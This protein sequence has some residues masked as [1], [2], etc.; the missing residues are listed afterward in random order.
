MSDSSAFYSALSAN[1]DRMTRAQDRRQMEKARLKS[2]VEMYSIKSALDVACG[3]GLHAILLAELGVQVTAT[4]NSADMLQQA[5]FNAEQTNVSVRWLRCEMQNLLD[6]LDDR[7]DAIFCLGN[8]IP[9]LLEFEDLQ[10]TIAQFVALLKARGICLLQIL[11]YE[12][13]LQTKNRIVGIHRAESLEFVRFYDFFSELI[14]F[15]ILTIDWSGPNARH[16]LQS[17]QLRPYRAWEIELCLAHYLFSVQKYSSLSLEPFEPS[18]S[19][20]LVI[21]GAQSR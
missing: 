7:F 15:N 10:R 12:R 5:Q 14:Q 8:S 20:D 18:S 4:D 21:L 1:Y 6:C 16:S 3:T 17:T 9:H 13:I 11:N 2:L 19:T